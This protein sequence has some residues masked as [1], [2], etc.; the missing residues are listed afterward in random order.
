MIMIKNI[1]ITIKI[2]F[3]LGHFCLTIPFG[4]ALNSKIICIIIFD[5]MALCNYL[6]LYL[7]SILLMNIMRMMYLFG[8][9]SMSISFLDYLL[10]EQIT[11]LEIFGLII[12]YYEIIIIIICVELSKINKLKKITMKIAYY[13]NIFLYIQNSSFD[14]DKYETHKVM[15]DNDELFLERTYLNINNEMCSLCNEKY[16]EK[17]IVVQTIR[18]HHLLHYACH[19]PLSVIS[20]KC[21]ECGGEL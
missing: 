15:M 5:I 18:C 2:L 1:F 4:K 10:G 9:M 11:I 12:A 21:F 7:S 3:H 6:S 19:E 16:H 14:H 8:I 13:F 17:D 20:N